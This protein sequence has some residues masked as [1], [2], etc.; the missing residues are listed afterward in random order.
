MMRQ[1]HIL[2]IRPGLEESYREAH[3]AVE[4]AIAA[5]RRVG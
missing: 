5:V 4:T 3:R 1:V 2:T